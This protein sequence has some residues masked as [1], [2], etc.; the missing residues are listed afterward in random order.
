MN[1][2]G[3]GGYVYLSIHTANEANTP[4]LDARGGA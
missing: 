3:A 4:R 2:A 1:A